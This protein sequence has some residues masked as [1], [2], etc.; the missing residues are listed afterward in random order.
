MKLS[1]FAWDAT[2]CTAMLAIANLT[3]SEW[4]AIKDFVFYGT[5]EDKKIFNAAKHKVTNF[6]ANL[7]TPRNHN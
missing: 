4:Q 5:I 3:V 7:P 6:E 1:D 2:N